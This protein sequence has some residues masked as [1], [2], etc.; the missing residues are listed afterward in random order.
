MTIAM[1][2]HWKVRPGDEAKFRRAWVRGTEL[3]R[4]AAGSGGSRLH[5]DLNNEGWYVAYARWPSLEARDKAIAALDGEA[6]QTFIDM[7]ECILETGPEYIIEV[8][9][10]ILTPEPDVPESWRAPKGPYAV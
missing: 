7:R 10:D 8:T 1:I 9:D 4:D 3:V 5:R 2:Y 6:K